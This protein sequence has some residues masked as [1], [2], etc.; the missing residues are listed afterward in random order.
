MIVALIL[1]SMEVLVLTRLEIIGVFAWL[2]SLG[3]TAKQTSMNV[4]QI[5][6]R[7]EPN[8]Q[9]MLTPLP[10]LVDLDFLELTVRIMT[11]IVLVAPV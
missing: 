2:D 1:V 7:M 5:L 3:K 11:M 6:A 10:A 8:V 4:P 9:T